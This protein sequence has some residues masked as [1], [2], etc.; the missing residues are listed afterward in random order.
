MKKNYTIELRHD[1]FFRMEKEYIS[2]D[3][4]NAS[5]RGDFY[6]HFYRSTQFSWGLHIEMDKLVLFDFDVKI[7]YNL[8]SRGGRVEM[9]VFVG[10]NHVGGDRFRQG[11]F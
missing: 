4:T 9:S 2:L 10:G 7:V 11:C 5:K 1:T 6:V 8:E 3:E